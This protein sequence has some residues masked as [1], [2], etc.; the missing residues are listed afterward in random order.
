MGVTNIVATIKQIH[1]E[2]IIFV[3]IGKFYSVYGKDA[4]IISYIFQ[5]KIKSVE[6]NIHSVGFPETALNKVIAKVEEL[7]INYLFLDRRNNYEIDEK[8]DNKNLNRYNEY[9]TKAKEY[10]KYKVKLDDLYEYLSLTIKE[11]YSKD[12]IIKMEKAIN[13]RR[14]I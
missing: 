13:E 7:K 6:N 3:K 5:Y 2:Y 11:K 12:I 8:S 1:T 14:K 9:Y 4:D 10:V